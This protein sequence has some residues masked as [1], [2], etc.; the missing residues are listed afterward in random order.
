MNLVEFLKNNGTTIHDLKY[1]Y[2]MLLL[3]AVIG[4]VLIFVLRSFI[5]VELT[6][7]QVPG[8]F[9]AA[10]FVVSVCTAVGLPILC[11][12]LFANRMRRQTHTSETD[13]LKFERS[14]LY[15]AMTTP[16]VGLMAQIMELQRS[17][18]AGTMIMT[19]YA[20]YY[21]Y[22]SKRR[23]DYDRRMFRVR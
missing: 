15:I 18:L 1:R 9:S 10:V 20:V 5:T 17:H 3:P 16:Y 8:A 12:T 21:Y 23:I 4:F 14:L 19:L 6:V 13:W 22:P 11:R 2:L 7:P